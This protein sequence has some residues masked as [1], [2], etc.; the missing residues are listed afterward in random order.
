M[1]DKLT[2]DELTAVSPEFVVLMKKEYM[3]VAYYNCAKILSYIMDYK[4]FENKDRKLT[5]AGPDKEKIIAA[6][7]THHVNFLISEFG[8]IT[9]RRSFEDN[10]FGKYLELGKDLTV[11]GHVSVMRND[12]GPGRAL[13]TPGVK[14]E[15]PPVPDWLQS[16]L[17]VQ[18]RR[19]G[20][21]IVDTVENKRIKVQFPEVGEKTFVWPGA[22]DQS[23][24]E[25]V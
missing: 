25:C 20:I 2:Y 15:D 11:Q 24:L 14:K 13:I 5:S 12:A 16:G 19:F 10:N 8:E 23:F 6:L 3:Y 22:F 18:N 21:G 7:S 9:E 4:L 17:L 1:R